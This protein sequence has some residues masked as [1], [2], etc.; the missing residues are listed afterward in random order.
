[1][2]MARMY[3]T[4]LSG[5]K[6]G[7]TNGAHNAPIAMI[8]PRNTGFDPRQACRENALGRHA[9]RC[10]EHRIRRREIIAF[11]M[12]NDEFG[13]RDQVNDSDRAVAPAVT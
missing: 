10:K 12:Q 3:A 4:S 7:R 13:E 9:S 1:M 6:I 5:D 8:A 2:W 11:A